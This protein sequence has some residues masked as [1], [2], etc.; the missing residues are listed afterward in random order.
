MFFG[1]FFDSFEFFFCLARAVLDEGYQGQMMKQFQEFRCQ[2][3][4]LNLT[5]W[6]ALREAFAPSPEALATLL[7]DVERI[8]PFISD[9]GVS[10]HGFRRRVPNRSKSSEHV[11]FL[12]ARSMQ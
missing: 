2:A 7:A 5:P 6:D 3:N 4:S 10:Y 8:F 11:L 9:P 1:L 12:N